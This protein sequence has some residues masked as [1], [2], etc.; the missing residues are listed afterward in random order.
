MEIDR[1]TQGAYARSCG[2]F[3]AGPTDVVDRLT[4]SW[5]RPATTKSSFATVAIDPESG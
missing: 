1:A 3:A 5:H 4:T 2:Q